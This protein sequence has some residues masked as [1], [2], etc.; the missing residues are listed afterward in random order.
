MPHIRFAAVLALA[1]GSVS[2]VEFVSAQT[3]NCVSTPPAHTYRL[4][5]DVRLDCAPDPRVD[6]L[7]VTVAAESLEGEGYT[8][9]GLVK[10]TSEDAISVQSLVVDFLS[11][12]SQVVAWCS[13]PQS[14]ELNAGDSKEFAASCR[15][16]RFISGRGEGI[17]TTRVRA[18]P[19]SGT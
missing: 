1:L 4:G 6:A 2:L 16:E 12:N 19:F 18:S 8:A 5:E 15:I 3:S 7:A 17:V 13:I 14:I 9:E 11:K 10:N